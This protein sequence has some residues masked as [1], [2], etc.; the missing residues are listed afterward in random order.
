MK[1][2][3]DILLLIGFFYLLSMPLAFAIDFM[4]SDELTL[5]EKFLGALAM[6][7]LWPLVMLFMPMMSCGMPKHQSSMLNRSS[8]PRNRRSKPTKNL[9][10]KT[11]KLCPYC[12]M[13]IQ[14][15]GC[16]YSS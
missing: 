1:L 16:G 12:G 4:F 13:L 10:F 2:S 6:A 11:T 9:P 15:C 7:F 3:P 14:R 8:R 5:Y